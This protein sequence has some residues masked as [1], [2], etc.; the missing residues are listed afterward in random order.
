MQVESRCKL[1]NRGK[2]NSDVIRKRDST[3]NDEADAFP[4]DMGSALNIRRGEDTQ[5]DIA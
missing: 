2:L 4:V 1:Q 3:I 5:W